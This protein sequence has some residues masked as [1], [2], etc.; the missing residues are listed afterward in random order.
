[1]A[2]EHQAGVG[3]PWHGLCPNRDGWE[4]VAVVCAN[5]VEAIFSFVLIFGAEKVKIADKRWATGWWRT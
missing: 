4:L 2:E 3:N 1:M 5:L